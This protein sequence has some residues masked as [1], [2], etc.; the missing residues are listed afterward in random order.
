MRWDSPD[1]CGTF[2]ACCHLPTSG[3][4]VVRS[5]STQSQTLV[6]PMPLHF[7]LFFWGNIQSGSLCFSEDC[8]SW[9]CPS[10]LHGPLL[11]YPCELMWRQLTEAMAHHW[12]MP[13]KVSILRF[14][15]CCLKMAGA[16]RRNWNKES[17]QNFAAV[18]INVSSKVLISKPLTVVQGALIAKSLQPYLGHLTAAQF[19]LLWLAMADKLYKNRKTK[20]TKSQD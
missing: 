8:K 20:M 1:T 7:T 12:P 17:L 2:G 18:L 15:S 6:K 16:S 11:R 4:M 3:N 14:A 9:T 13:Q 19:G 5:V 10:E